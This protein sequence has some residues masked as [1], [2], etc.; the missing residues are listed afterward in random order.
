MA[1]EEIEVLSIAFA[2]NWTRDEDIV[3][4]LIAA[5]QDGAKC[6]TPKWTA[7]SE[8]LPEIGVA[9]L[10]WS[11]GY[12]FD[13]AEIIEGNRWEN[14]YEQITPTHWKPLPEKP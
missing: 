9:V 8:E 14:G 5:W 13:E 3:E 4:G 6:A 2:M 11:E 7:C 10:A 1:P 12:G